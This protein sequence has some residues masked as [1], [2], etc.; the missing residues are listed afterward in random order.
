MEESVR[1]TVTMPAQLAAAVDAAVADG[2][3]DSVSALLATAVRRY[4]DQLAD[5]RMTAQAARLDAETERALT[6]RVRRDPQTGWERL[7]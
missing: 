6:N 3:A 2:A 5:D 4:L 1:R 7:T